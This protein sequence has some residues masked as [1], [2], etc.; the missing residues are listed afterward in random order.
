MPSAAKTNS[1]LVLSVVTSGPDVMVVVGAMP[2]A[3]Q[4]HSAGVGSTLPAA[5]L[6]RTAKSCSPQ[7]RFVYVCG[8]AHGMKP[9]L[10]TPSSSAHSKVAPWMFDW[11]LKVASLP[12]VGSAGPLRMAVSGMGVI[13]HSWRAGLRSTVPA[14]FRA[15]TCST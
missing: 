1:A 7:S 15:R 11:N 8:E 12:S 3:L 2:S 5:S 13:T 6:A 9:P 14:S 10:S 4:L